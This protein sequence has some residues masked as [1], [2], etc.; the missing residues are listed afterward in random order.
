MEKAAI[1]LR[2]STMEQASEGVSL[3]AQEERVRAYCQLA[4]LEPMAMIREEGVSGGKP[5]ATR[6]GGAELVDLVAHKKVAHVVALK[7]DRLFRDA[8]DALNQTRAWDKAGVS[9]HLVD[10]GGMAFNSSSAMGRF[11][12]S[13]M[14]AV[15]ELERNLIA[16]R[17]EMALSHKKAHLEAYARTP[18]G[19]DRQGDTLT[20]NRQEQSIIDEI[21]TWRAAGWTLGKIAGELT[22][23]QIP[24]K[25]GGAWYPGT[26]KYLLENNLYQ[27][28]ASS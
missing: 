5:L 21:K 20:P 26:V 4:G 19:Y 11:F 13:T 17:T 25:R 28:A 8:A 10:L 18:Y 7:L 9:L 15:G 16:E 6:P 23:R 14:A 12:L 2:V 1:Y 24:T 3:E 27:G 22:R